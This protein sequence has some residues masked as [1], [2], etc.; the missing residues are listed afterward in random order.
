MSLALYGR[1]EVLRPEIEVSDRPE[2]RQISGFGWR[3]HEKFKKS[4]YY[5]KPKISIIANPK[6]C[7]QKKKRHYINL[8][9]AISKNCF[10]KRFP[11]A[12]DFR[13]V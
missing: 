4:R 1:G 8:K 10:T 3:D 7:F 2:A 6:I 11:R 12:S 5:R 9:L 13:I